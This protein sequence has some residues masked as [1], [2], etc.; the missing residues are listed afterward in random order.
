MASS[1]QADVAGYPNTFRGFYQ[2]LAHIRDVYAS[3]RRV[4]ARCQHLAGHRRRS[5]L[6]YATIHNYDWAAHAT[7]TATYLNSFGPGYQMLFLS[8]LD[9]DAAYYQITQAATAGGTTPTPTEPKFDTMASWL[10][11]IISQTQ[12]RSMLW[13]TPNGNRIYRTE[14]NTDGHYQD[15]RPEYFLNPDQW[16]H[17]YEPVG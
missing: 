6:R 11:M 3:Q 16:P 17:A 14:N 5:H 13:Q 7:R 4:G 9:R 10:G 8:P 2:A 1:G 12:K 15:N